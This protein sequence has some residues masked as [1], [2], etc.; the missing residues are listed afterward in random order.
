MF[1]LSDDRPEQL[2]CLMQL[3]LVIIVIA[4][5][6]QRGQ[7]KSAKQRRIAQPSARFSKSARRAHV[8][9]RDLGAFEK[10]LIKIVNICAH[11]GI[12]DGGCLSVASFVDA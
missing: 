6:A 9:A 2:A 10:M 8:C 12:W 5:R 11:L 7:Q 1:G 4:G 3:G